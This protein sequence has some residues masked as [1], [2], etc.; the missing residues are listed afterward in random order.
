MLQL[1]CWFVRAML[2]WA[3]EYKEEKKTVGGKGRRG[4]GGEEKEENRGEGKH[5]PAKKEK[6]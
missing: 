3:F 2:A 6:R 1:L 5:P 4:G